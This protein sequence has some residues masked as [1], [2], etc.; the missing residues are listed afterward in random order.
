MLISGSIIA[1]PFA[2]GI[3]NH[4]ELD[5]FVDSSVVGMA[6]LYTSEPQNMPPIFVNESAPETEETELSELASYARQSI[7]R[8]IAG[9]TSLSEEVRLLKHRTT[10]NLAQIE[11]WIEKIHS[12]AENN[13]ENS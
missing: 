5:Q 3:D 13:D 12:E 4:L 1:L 8:L 6:V 11:A 2:T 7:E 10:E 9:A